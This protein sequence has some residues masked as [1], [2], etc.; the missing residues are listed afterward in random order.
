[1]SR[2][3]EPAGW[4]TFDGSGDAVG[5]R[6]TTAPRG[7]VSVAESP[8]DRL[9]AAGTALVGRVR[10]GVATLSV[11]VRAVLWSRT[12]RLL[13]LALLA[14]AVG[15]VPPWLVGDPFYDGVAPA[16]HYP[17]ERSGLETWGG[18]TLPLAVLAV[19]VLVVRRGRT[20]VAS[21]ALVGAGAVA[22]A[23][24]TVL[25]AAAAP[26]LLP[27]PGVVLTAAGGVAVLALAARARTHPE[28]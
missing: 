5:E 22:V 9:R 18:A 20:G 7:R 1:M 27:G 2:P 11:R 10:G 8:L 26:W 3:P 6:F 12:E 24:D 16:V 19:G 23:A 13:V 25:R 15:A 4:R 14:V 28:R 17:G 21:S